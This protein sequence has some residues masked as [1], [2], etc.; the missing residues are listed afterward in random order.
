M[1]GN[2][3]DSP[4]ART[5]FK[6]ELPPFFWQVTRTLFRDYFLF[7]HG[8]RFRNSDHI[9][10][11]GQLLFAPNHCSYY[12]PP[13]IGTAIPWQLRFMAWEALFKV[14]LLAQW[15]RTFGAF[16]VRLKSADR[17]A[18]ELAL[19]VL[20]EGGSMVIFPEGQRC[21]DGKLAPFEKGMA[22]MALNVG[23][24]VVPVAITGAYQAYNRYHFLPKFGYRRIT[25]K[26]YPPIELEPITNPRE[27]RDAVAQLNRNVQKVINRRMR[28][29]DRLCAMCDKCRQ[30]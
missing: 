27:M 21:Y 17:N 13:L 29:Y 26:F 14:P 11:H 24:T 2:P 20:R 3:T 1:T 9:P 28:A 7:F 25:V 19:N 30:K 15:M 18:V 10:A 22:R 4:S 16:P 12:D 6:V 23:A 8:V 5:N